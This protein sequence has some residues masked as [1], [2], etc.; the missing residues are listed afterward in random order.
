MVAWIV[1]I[2]VAIGL[3]FLFTREGFV[4]FSD[5]TQVQRTVA[6]QNSSYAQRTNHMIPPPGPLVPIQGIESPFRVNM[7]DA[8]IP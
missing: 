2:L 3:Y 1:L 6:T 4:D 7:F 5:K 8:Y